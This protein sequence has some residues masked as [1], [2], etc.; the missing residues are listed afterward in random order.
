MSKT[1][2]SPQ[3]PT[4]SLSTTYEALRDFLL[5]ARSRPCT[6]RPDQ[7]EDQPTKEM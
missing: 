6:E 1:E 3:R 4:G 5:Q 2:H 7:T